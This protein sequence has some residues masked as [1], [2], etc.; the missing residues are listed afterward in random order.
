[1]PCVLWVAAF[2]AFGPGSGDSPEGGAYLGAGF[3]VDQTK[4]CWTVNYRIAV[5][6][7]N[8][9]GVDY[10]LQYSL[11][12]ARVKVSYPCIGRR[13]NGGVAASSST[14]ASLSP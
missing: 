9:N 4:L 5:E 6:H 7:F 1:M 2:Y 14:K 11:S 12:S 13:E 8:G 3:K 10:S